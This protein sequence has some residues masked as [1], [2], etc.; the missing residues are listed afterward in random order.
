M[1]LDVEMARPLQRLVCSI[2][3]RSTMKKKDVEKAMALP[4][5]D[6]KGGSF[7]VPL[8]PGASIIAPSEEWEELL[9][10]FKDFVLNFD[11]DADGGQLIREMGIQRGNLP[12]FLATFCSPRAGLF[13]QKLS[14]HFLESVASLGSAVWKKNVQKDYVTIRSACE[15]APVVVDNSG[16]RF[17]CSELVDPEDVQFFAALNPPREYCSPVVLSVLRKAGLK[18]LT[19]EEMFLSAARHVEATSQGEATAKGKELLALLATRFP[20]LKWSSKSFAAL[21]H[22]RI[23]PAVPVH[24][25]AQPPDSLE[26]VRVMSLD[27]PCTLFQHASVAWTQLPLLHPGTFAGWPKPLLQRFSAIKD[28]EPCWQMQ[29]PPPLDVVV[30]NLIEVARRWETQEATD[31]V[32]PRQQIVVY[33]L[34]ALDAMRSRSHAMQNMVQHSLCMVKFLVASLQ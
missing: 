9:G 29:D 33:H 22:I 18:S 15:D 5:F 11:A 12:E 32:T 28:W 27:V 24:S 26:H 17:R 2:L 16:R 21:S 4:I 20:S 1:R 25:D 8:T 23:F 31:K 34:A 6:T 14:V 3:L 19:D 10:Q 30:A 7:A 13:D